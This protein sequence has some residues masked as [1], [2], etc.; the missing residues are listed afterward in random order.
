M[1][2]VTLAHMGYDLELLGDGTLHDDDDDLMGRSTFSRGHCCTW[3]D[4]VA[5]FIDD[6]TL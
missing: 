3:R 6:N 4:D 5:P 2:H 1:T